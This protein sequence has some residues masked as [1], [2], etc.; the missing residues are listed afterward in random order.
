[1][2]SFGIA[3]LSL[4][5]A[6]TLLVSLAAIEPALLKQRFSRLPLVLSALLFL[7][8]GLVSLFW[9]EADRLLP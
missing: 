6:V 5:F 3:G 2:G 1:M 9:T 7:L 8:W 4:G